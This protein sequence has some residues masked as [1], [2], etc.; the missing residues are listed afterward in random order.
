MQD[1]TSGIEKKINPKLFKSVRI[2][3]EFDTMVGTL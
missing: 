1:R 3:I 2:L